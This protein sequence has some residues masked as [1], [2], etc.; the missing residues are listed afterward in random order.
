MTKIG[1]QCIKFNQEGD[2][3]HEYQPLHNIIDRTDKTVKYQESDISY[4]DQIKDFEVPSTELGIDLNNPVDIECQ[5]SYDGT[6]NLI[7]N[8]DKNPPRIINSRFSVTEDNKYKIISRNQV[9][10]TNLYDKNNVDR[11]TRLFRNVNSIPVIQLVEVSNYGQ[12]KG[13]NYTFYIKLA[14]NDYNKTDIVAESGTVS[15]YHGTISDVTTIY[16]ALLEELTDKSIELKLSNI[17]TTFSRVYL[18]YTR[19]SSDLNGVKY[20]KSYEVIKPYD[21]LENT[22]TISLN[23]FEEVKE[24][25]E[26]QL[27][28]KYNLVTAVKTQAQV[29]NML[30]FGNTQGILLN[31][32]DLQ[33]IS[34]YI[35]V[36]CTQKNETIGYLDSDYKIQQNDSVEQTEYYNPLNTYFYLGYW[37]DEMYRLGIVYIMQDDSLSPVYNLR[38]CQFTKLEATNIPSDSK[39]NNLYI[40]DSEKLNY[41]P[42]D[43]FIEEKNLSNTKGVFKLPNISIFSEGETKPLYFKFT[44]SKD[45][46]SELKVNKVKGF[47]FVRQKRIPTI[48]AQGLSIGID[49]TSYVPIIYNDNT[50][51]YETESFISQTSA[52]LTTSYNDRIIKINNKGSSALL[53]LDACVNPSLQ[54]TFNGA[55]YTLS[56]FISG[57]VNQ[58]TRRYKWTFKEA[59]L[60]SGI[61]KSKLLF[62]PDDTPLKFIDQKGFTTRAGSAED[63]SQFVFVSEKSYNWNN[64]KLA[65]GNYV[66]FVATNVQLD[67][68][69]IY[70]IRISN[71]STLFLKQYFTIRANDQSAYYAI[72]DRYD[73]NTFIADSVIDGYRGDC[74]T[75]TITLRLQRNFIDSDAPVTEIIVN[76]NTWLDNYSGLTSMNKDS[77]SNINRADVNTVPIGSWITF[78]VL[79]N[80]NLGLRSED[81]THTEEAALMGNNRSFYPLKGDNVFSTSKVPESFILNE[82]YSTSLSAKRYQIVPDVPY[83][84]ELFDTRVMFSNVQVEDSFQNA[85][86]IFQ[87]LSYKDLDR[88]Y[89]AIV[90]LLPWGVNLFCVFEHGLG[91]IPINE[92]ALISTNTG[93]SIHMYG[94]GVLQNQIT[95]ISPDFGSIWKESIVRTP[96]GIYGVDT[97]AKK[98]WRFSENKGLELLSDFKIQR[99]LNDNI[100]LKELEKYPVIG[101][102]NVKTHFNM[103]K[104]DVMFTFYNGNLTWNLCYNERLD[105]WITEYTWTPLYSANINNIFY[106]LDR[107]RAKRLGAVF[108]SKS[109]IGIHLLKIDDFSSP[110]YL[111]DVSL[112]PII[113]G[114]QEIAKHYN[115]NN[116]KAA[117]V[118][119]SNLFN[120]YK[121]RINSISTF[122]TND[123]QNCPVLLWDDSLPVEDSGIVGLEYVS[124]YSGYVLPLI[125]ETNT[126]YIEIDPKIITTKIK[127][128]EQGTQFDDYEF[129]YYDLLL[130]IT[131]FPGVTLNQDNKVDIWGSTVTQNIAV[132]IDSDNLKALDKEKYNELLNNAFFVHGRAGIFDDINYF[133]SDITNQI[134]P[135]KWYDKQHPFEFEFVVN[136]LTG[137]HKI[138][139]NLVII[140]NNAEPESFEFEIIGDSYSF[141]KAGIYKAETFANNESEKKSYIWGNDNPQRPVGEYVEEGSKFKRSQDFK[142]H[143]N[144]KWDIKIDWDPVLNQYSLVIPQ[145]AKNIIKYGRVKGNIQYREDSWHLVIKPILY[146]ESIAK[147][148]NGKLDENNIIYNNT[149][150]STRI[151]DKFL[152]VRVKYSGKQLAIITGLKTLM[153]LSYS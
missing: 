105:K 66:P 93:Q 48:L 65:R 11:D 117:I 7:I 1:I 90:K 32:R 63:V 41:L 127:Q 35:D 109:D 94:A 96:L 98:I 131:V 67:D 95:L 129:K 99:F 29:Q 14:D 37:P 31:H 134:L 59:T 39:Y 113:S 34:Y 6:V 22:I 151:R 18:Y 44:L 152:K 115:I 116:F 136:N 83:V 89:G 43:I 108:A 57:K 140:S 135:T 82:G 91:I 103:Y 139:N 75:N 137:L 84:K 46:V 62:V 114:E 107:E 148:I 133:D 112:E 125:S 149:I 88:Q 54:S 24:I 42:A 23:G 141:N 49:T 142:L 104:G 12:L 119:N 74:F 55:E 45:I 61:F 130:N 120:T 87:G 26:E 92:K 58:V 138:F 118:Y 47:F 16:G 38:G 146:K 33:T 69:C 71:Y 21:I 40:K 77:W 132:A 78:K 80:Y 17:D 143:K 97:Y 121:F 102:R 124:D 86:R 51:R 2:L 50:S 27:N 81:T 76:P 128:E 72:T 13:G 68:N 52:V 3:A 70:N 79:S 19:T 64:Y 101:S 106:S 110:K 122:S 4:S 123:S 150:Q 15:I 153:T 20:S 5:P 85:Y 73:I 56:K 9:T 10:Q 111:W 36:R 60:D 8:D 100:N 147:Y 126:S 30:F 145:E 28:I 25:D 53:C 144:S